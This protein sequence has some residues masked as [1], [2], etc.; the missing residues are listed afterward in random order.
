MVTSC[1]SWGE[2]GT[3]GGCEGDAPT[4]S[5][6]A[7]RISREHFLDREKQVVGRPMLE[8]EARC[9]NPVGFFSQIGVTGCRHDHH[10]GL[11]V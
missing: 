6:A 5:D 7:M 10:L 4:W 11:R 1:V 2:R 9:S 3:G 8:H